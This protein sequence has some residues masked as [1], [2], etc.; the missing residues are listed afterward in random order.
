LNNVGEIDKDALCCLW[1]QVV[2]ARLILNCAEIGLEH[3]VEVPRLG[4]LT[5][6]TAVRTADLFKTRRL[7]TLPGLEVL[8]QMIGSKTAVTRQAFGQRVVERID[9]A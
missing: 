3:H 6:G 7:A 9:M 5:A 4:P 1:T 8:L 2:Q